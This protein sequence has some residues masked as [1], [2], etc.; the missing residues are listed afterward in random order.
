MKTSR[1]AIYTRK[2]S[3]E[4][5]DQLFN[6]LHAQREACEAYMLSQKHEGWQVLSAKYD[7][8]GFSG[9]NMQRPGL[10]KLLGDIAAGKIDTVV[11]Y[12]IDRL[13]R[14]LADFAKIVETFDGKGVSFVSVTQ[15]FNTD[16][17]YGPAHLECTAL[18][19][20]V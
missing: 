2:S 15:Q 6:S 18:I 10:K 16:D 3:E 8:G 17:L 1:C 12:K 13:T 19:C 7:D 4:G 11:V 5:L 9:G 14:S 20:S